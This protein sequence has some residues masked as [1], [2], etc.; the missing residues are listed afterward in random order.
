MPEADDNCIS[1]RH[2]SPPPT[3]LRHRTKGRLASGFQ[4]GEVFGRIALLSGQVVGVKFV[5]KAGVGHPYRFAIGPQTV[6]IVVS[7]SL[8]V[9]QVLHRVAGGE[10][11]SDGDGRKGKDQQGERNSQRENLP[12][13]IRRWREGNGQREKRTTL[14]LGSLLSGCLGWRWT[15]S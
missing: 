9:V 10:G 4:G 15:S 12:P 3:W 13:A 8:E 6:S 2:L 11:C 7:R 5:V 1:Y 14:F